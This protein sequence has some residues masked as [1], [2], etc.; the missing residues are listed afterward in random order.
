MTVDI[1]TIVTIAITQAVSTVTTFY[2]LKWLQNGHELIN[3][4]GK[5]ID[6]FVNGKKDEKKATTEN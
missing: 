6:E 4:S 5:K 2:M 3:K 1:N